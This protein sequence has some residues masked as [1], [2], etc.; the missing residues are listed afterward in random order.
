MVPI[1]LLR[2]Y[3]SGTTRAG[4]RRPMVDS[5][6]GSCRILSIDGVSLQYRPP[7]WKR[8]DMA[9]QSPKVLHLLC[10]SLLV[11]AFLAVGVGSWALANDSGEG[12]ANIGAGILM[13]FGYT[14]GALGLVVGAAA[15]IAFG[16]VRR[17]GRLH[18]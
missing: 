1:E 7:S 18:T 15:L 11:I 6:E 2:E 16:I 14:V 17:Q 8:D 13:L 12:G 5:Y 4:P 10:T 3:Q 9:A